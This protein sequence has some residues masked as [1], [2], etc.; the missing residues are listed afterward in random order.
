MGV[1]GINILRSLI[2]KCMLLTR[3]QGWLCG[4]PVGSGIRIEDPTMN[5]LLDKMELRK[6]LLKR[7]CT[8]QTIRLDEV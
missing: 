3:M 6:T 8:K 1:A 7:Y 5:V 2:L 4:I